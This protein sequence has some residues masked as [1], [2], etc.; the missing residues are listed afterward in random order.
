VSGARVVILSAAKDLLFAH[1]PNRP[2]PQSPDRTHISTS[3][4]SEESDVS[5]E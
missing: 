1:T 4:R 5:V 2:I 3:E